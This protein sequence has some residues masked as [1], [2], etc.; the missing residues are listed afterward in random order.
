MQNLRENYHCMKVHQDEKKMKTSIITLTLL[1]NI[2]I[3]ILESD[4]A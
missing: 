3:Y 4:L 2:I 1:G